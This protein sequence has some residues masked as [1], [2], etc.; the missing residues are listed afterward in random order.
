[1]FLERVFDF[2]KNLLVKNTLSVKFLSNGFKRMSNCEFFY[3][4]LNF[5][6]LQK[7]DIGL[8]IFK[9]NS[10]LSLHYFGKFIP[11]QVRLL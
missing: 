6:V 7:E 11:G 3:L 8:K 1:M 9:A 5:V 10:N 4:F 2:V